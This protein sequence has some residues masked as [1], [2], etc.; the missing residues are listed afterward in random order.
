ML[1]KGGL[2]GTDG[3]GGCVRLSRASSSNNALVVKIAA[4][5][6]SIEQSSVSISS[7]DLRDARSCSP[8]NSAS[9]H[10]E[11]SSKGDYG[12]AGCRDC[13]GDTKKGTEKCNCD[14]DCSE[15]CSC[16]MLVA[17]STTRGN[18]TDMTKDGADQEEELRDGEKKPKAGTSV[19]SVAASAVSTVLTVWES[20]QQS[21][22]GCCANAGAA[23]LDMDQEFSICKGQQ[24]AVSSHS[25]KA[26]TAPE[27]ESGRADDF[28]GVAITA[29]DRL[30]SA[31][32]RIF[33][34]MPAMA[35][36][37]QAGE[38]Q[39][40]PENL[41]AAAAEATTLELV[42]FKHNGSRTPPAEDE[43][44]YLLI[45]STSC[46]ET[47]QDHCEAPDSPTYDKTQKALALCT[48]K[49]T[50]KYDAADPPETNHFANHHFAVGK[51]S[52]RPYC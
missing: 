44:C 9:Q 50:N 20:E 5:P 21:V 33:S 36:S 43:N 40:V 35:S 38:V 39:F 25:E 22:S 12:K 37:A 51:S 29:A 6:C 1:D 14:C 15:A 24:L 48:D 26:A 46:S 31:L 27:L 47:N 52:P 13:V 34:S 41:Q 4:T 49:C 18:E 19:D 16:G 3:A 2:P 32:P 30:L 8:D 23:E 11:H 10:T 28:S 42:Q 17:V 7:Q 45:Q